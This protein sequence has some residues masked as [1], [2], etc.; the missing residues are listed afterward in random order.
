[1][2][3]TDRRRLREYLGVDIESLRDT[4]QSLATYAAD[5]DILLKGT[6]AGT[7]W[8][9]AQLGCGLPD[10]DWEWNT[11]TRARAGY[12][13]GL[14]AV[15]QLE[16]DQ[17]ERY[18]RNSAYP[19]ALMLPVPHGVFRELDARAAGLAWARDKPGVYEARML[20]PEQ[21]APPLPMRVG[22]RIVY[23]WGALS[24]SWTRDEI[25]HAVASGARIVRIDGGVAWADES[26]LLAP[27]VDRCFELRRQADTQ[28]LKVWLKF[29]ANSLTGAFAQ[30]PETDQVA[31]GDYADDPDYEQVGHYDWIWRRKVSHISARAH[32]HWA[33]T[34]TS[35]ARIE[36]S[37]EIAH[38]GDAWVYSDTDSVLATKLLTRNVGDKLGEWKHEGSARNF[39]AI[40]PKVYTY[41]EVGEPGA[42]GPARRFARAK[43]IPDVVGV[44]DRV[45]AGERVELDRGVRSFLVAARTDELF[46]RND[47]HRA[48]KPGTDWV[49]GRLRDG[50]RTRA[51]SVRD[52]ER[53]P[54]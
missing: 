30:D 3:G 31:L 24:G 37:K 18:D 38:A 5:H 20:V 34:L 36:L 42:Y 33:A 23:P 1:M 29:L 43:G 17:V 25:Q 52:L 47:G 41:D 48:L 16:A 46:A 10:A 9:T 7:A 39:R 53:L 50:V 28:A 26:P 54:R 2:V 12:Y 22:S 35:R 4:L 13:G 45:A 6:V 40:A 27:H 15:A 51:P 8:A 49:G 14:V 19:A 21:L 11:Y 44:W 32:V